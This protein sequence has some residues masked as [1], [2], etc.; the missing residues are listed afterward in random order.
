MLIEMV[1]YNILPLLRLF[2]QIF[3]F[4]SLSGVWCLMLSFGVCN[5]CFVSIFFFFLCFMLLLTFHYFFH[6]NAVEIPS[7][8]VC[9]HYI[10]FIFNNN[11]NHKKVT[12]AKAWNR[13][14]CNSNIASLI[15]VSI[16]WYIWNLLRLTL[17]V[18]IS[19]EFLSQIISYHIISNRNEDI[20]NVC[21]CVCVLHIYVPV[22]LQIM[23]CILYV[24]DWKRVFRISIWK[25]TENIFSSI[26]HQFWTRLS[27]DSRWAKWIIGKRCVMRR[28][29]TNSY[30]IGAFDEHSRGLMWTRVQT[31]LWLSFLVWF[32]FT[33]PNNPYWIKL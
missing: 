26:Y 25:C 10:D 27:V 13:N 21:V 6:V 5:S 11:N 12:S 23:L 4:S 2:I 14:I 28:I 24:C 3:L 20:E 15:I 30:Q 22:T 8:R 33:E 17:I 16:T 32:V 18:C 29:F 7:S 9:M 1:A 31:T 19:N